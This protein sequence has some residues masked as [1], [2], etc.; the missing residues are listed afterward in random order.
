MN[1]FTIIILL[2]SSLI[3]SAYK[4]AD[5]IE[6]NNLES[7][8]FLSTNVDSLE[9]VAFTHYQN[10]EY[11][12]A[13]KNYLCLLQYDINNS[14]NI[15]NLACCYALLGKPEFAAKYL[16][17]SYKKGFSD[18]E[19]IKKDPDF[20]KVR[21]DSIF[22]ATMYNLYKLYHTDNVYYQNSL[23]ANSLIEFDINFPVR[24]SGSSKYDLLI[25]LHGYGDDKKNFS[26]LFK[27]IE[28]MIVVIP[29][30]P[31][32]FKVNKKI[33]YSWVKLNL[34]LD[35]EE[36]S[37][38][39]L[40]ENYIITLINEI[41]NKHPLGNVYIT[42]FSQGAMLSYLIGLKNSEIITGIAPFGGMLFSSKISQENWNDAKDLKIYIVHGTNDRTIE[43]KYA[44]F[45]D[46]LLYKNKL[47]HKLHKFNGGHQVTKK[48][49]TEAIEWMRKE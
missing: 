19:H 7:G 31:Y 26:E 42:G 22:D 11:E 13:I 16:E 12:K 23:E 35:E 5:D 30:A 29:E 43:F 47:P 34:N 39:E 6:I 38:W 4:S 3:F 15:Y 49:L 18:Y 36:A 41:N 25:A 27:D 17:I 48:L 44:E 8:N 21:K 10:K 33:G 14:N 20:E 24:Y 2:I 9:K 46:S 28:D 1:K 45:A 37:S 40:S 32:P